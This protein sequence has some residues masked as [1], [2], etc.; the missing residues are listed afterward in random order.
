MRLEYIANKRDRAIASM[1][2]RG[3]LLDGKFIKLS[4]AELSLLRKAAAICEEA[5]EREIEY[6]KDT[7]LITPFGEANHALENIL[8]E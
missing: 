2:N 1:V 6:S 7:D 5:A 3:G 8:E 4:Q